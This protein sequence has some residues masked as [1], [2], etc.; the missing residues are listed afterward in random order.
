MGKEFEADTLPSAH[1]VEN[2]AGPPQHPCL[3]LIL[4]AHHPLTEPSRHSLAESDL[5]T[6][7]RGE[8]S[9]TR[10]TEQGRRRLELQ[11]PDPW[12][13]SS[14]H[15]RLFRHLG[16]WA[17]EDTQSRNGTFVNGMPVARAF[18]VD[19]DI[20]ELGHTFFLFREAVQ[21]TSEDP[22]DEIVLPP[23]DRIPGLTTLWP[24]LAQ[25]FRA[26]ARVARSNVSVVIRGESGTG[27]ELIARAV[28]LLSERPGAFVAINCGAL[29]EALI[30]S[31]LFGHRKGAFSGA[32]EER[33]GLIR[34]ADRGTLLLDEIGEL[35]AHAQVALLRV[36]Q[37]RQVM[38]LGETRPLPVD[39]RLCAATHRDLDQLTADATFRA[40]LLARISGFTLELPPLR[41][42]RQD[43]GILVGDLLRRKMGP[44]ASKISF[45]K[46]AIRVLLAHPWPLNIR[47]LEKTL[48]RAVVLGGENPIGPEHFPDSVRTPTPSLMEAWPGGRS[49]GSAIPLVEA[50]EDDHRRAELLALLAEHQGNISAVA[51]AMNKERIQIRRWMRRYALSPES[52]R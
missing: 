15:A 1:P 39:L 22:L 52:Y 31:E 12:M 28:H 29:P 18:L 45:T 44:A 38:P 20:I 42:R 7:A 13:S 27:K 2:S 30:E 11:I 35:P 5:V 16:K 48:E 19:G 3:F 10:R 32:I 40:D 34:S 24:P 46:A 25:Q 23:I 36:L 49:A 41:E 47:S 33:P 6:L 14:V 17:I 9:I 50:Q 43:L 4:A 8:R 51:R 37:E 21:V 26:L